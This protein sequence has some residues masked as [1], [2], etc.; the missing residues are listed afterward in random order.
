MWHVASLTLAI[1]HATGFT[2]RQFLINFLL[3]CVF[4]VNGSLDTGFRYS[5]HDFKTM[6]SY[7]DCNKSRLT[8]KGLNLPS[9]K[10]WNPA[11]KRVTWT[12]GHSFFL[13]PFSPKF[14]LKLRASWSPEIPFLSSP[15]SEAALHWRA[16]HAALFFLSPFSSKREVTLYWNEMHATLFFL[17][18]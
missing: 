13:S 2:D 15:S 16:R 1:V 9:I 7:V 8:S 12:W 3:A 18:P 6:P 11:R 14:V 5:C 10:N 4:L 17:S